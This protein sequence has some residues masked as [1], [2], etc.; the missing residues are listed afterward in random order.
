MDS[1][2]INILIVDD[3]AIIRSIIKEH[4]QHEGYNITEAS[5]GIEA[6]E[7]LV[8]DTEKFNLIILDR[9]M[10]RMNGLEL[11]KQIKTRSDLKNIPVIMETGLSQKKDI[12]EGLDAGCYHYLTKPFEKELLVA[13][14][15]TAISEH[16]AYRSLQDNLKKQSQSLMLLDSG[17]FSYRS[18]AEAK[19][20]T[21]LLAAACPEPG[22]VAPGLSELLINAV[23]HGNL[24][25]SYNEK[26]QLLMENRWEQE[27][28][29]RL[30]LKKYADRTVSVAFSR[31]DK[32][33]SFLIQDKGRGFEWQHYLEFSP[34]RSNDINGRGIAMAKMMSFDTIDY[35]GKGNEVLVTINTQA[36]ESELLQKVNG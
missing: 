18:L 12:L 6:L 1:A 7:K 13:F 16:L 15:K 22:V 26:T 11:L 17:Y 2:E 30:N 33:I 20:L 10:P 27:I 21:M 31:E 24:E 3:E 19:I 14:V 8:A 28:S 36:E 25:I 34:E 23:E 4:L 5:N 35:L 9:N 32:E 29:K